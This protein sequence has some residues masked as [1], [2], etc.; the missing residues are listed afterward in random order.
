MSYR[1]KTYV[2]FDGDSDMN[3]YRL[4]EAWRATDGSRFNFINAHDINMAKDS[5]QVASIKR[6]LAERLNN[7]RIF[8]LLIGERTRLLRKFVRWEIE[9][10]IQSDLPIVCCNLNGKRSMDQGLCPALL[11][12]HLAIHVP[13]KKEAIRHAL[14]KWQASHIKHRQKKQDGPYYYSADTYHSLGL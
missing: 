10:A 12:K 8:V 5:S 14:A 11:R 3:Y 2:A 4:M 7:S 9:R 6:Q 13:Y 1:S